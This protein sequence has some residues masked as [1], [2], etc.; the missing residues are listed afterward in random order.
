[1]KTLTFLFLGVLLC[2]PSPSFA[3]DRRTA[4]RPKSRP[5]AGQASAIGATAPDARRADQDDGVTALSRLMAKDPARRGNDA[6]L[7]MSDFIWSR[8]GDA[9]SFIAREIMDRDAALKPGERIRD[10][11]LGV[12]R[13]WVGEN[14]A[15][16]ARIYF[17][18]GPGPAVPGWLEAEPSVKKL[19][20]D[21]SRRC[22][23]VFLK[24]IDR[25]TGPAEARA[26]GDKAGKGPKDDPMGRMK[27]AFTVGWV[28]AFLADAAKQA[29][30]AIFHMNKPKEPV[31]ADIKKDEDLPAPP[32]GTLAG[33][34]SKDP[35]AGEA[36][37]GFGMRYLY[38]EWGQEN[39]F[40]LKGNC[41][42]GPGGTCGRTLSITRYEDKDEQGRTVAGV[43][44]CDISQESDVFCR[45]FGL[46]HR[47]K[48]PFVLD[49]RDPGSM[50][51][52]LS[53]VPRGDDME[54][55]LAR[56]NGTKIQNA[57]G[58]HSIT[59]NRLSELK[60]GQIR[61]EGRTVLMGG[62][63]YYVGAQ[64]GDYLFILKEKLDGVSGPAGSR[65]LV[66]DFLVHAVE[67]VGRQNQVKDGQYIGTFR[68]RVDGVDKEVHYC[69]SYKPELNWFKPEASDS[70]RKPEPRP[71]PKNPKAAAQGA[72]GA[73][74]RGGTAGA[75]RTQA[76]PGVAQDGWPVIPGYSSDEG[77][78]KALNDKIAVENGSKVAR[79]Y[80]KSDEPD[81][82][83]RWAIAWKGGASQEI[84]WLQGGVEV[85]ADGRVIAL[86]LEDRVQWLDMRSPWERKAPD[87]GQYVMNHEPHLDGYY[88][89]ETGT[90]P[91]KFRD[92]RSES[93][94]GYAL[95]RTEFQ[96]E[97]IKTIG[98]RARRV[99]GLI[100]K[101]GIAKDAF[102]P[103]NPPRAIAVSRKTD[104]RGRPPVEFHG[105]GGEKKEVGMYVEGKTIHLFPALRA[106]PKEEVETS[107]QDGGRQ[108]YDPMQPLP[109]DGDRLGDAI[110]PSGANVKFTRVRQVQ[111]NPAEA[112][113]Y[114]GEV[115]GVRRWYLKFVYKGIKDN[116]N[117][118]FWS[119]EALVFALPKSDAASLPPADWSKVR[120]AGMDMKGAANPPGLP[121]SVG[122]YL[123]SEA[124]RS[125]EKAP[126]KGVWVVHSEAT[127]VAGSKCL[128]PVLWWGMSQEE[129][130]KACK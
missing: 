82:K 127:G 113:L 120:M 62:R 109:A 61:G 17:V 11:V 128:G 51:Y 59:F 40:L 126:E 108:K 37:G 14:P 80:L 129:A 45:K 116:P 1:M 77:E 103:G 56:P 119:Q 92:V 106:H 3:T 67:R 52:K 48:D 81:P 79:L 36:A 89:P 23:P 57:D 53:L 25:W 43:L 47:S 50:K 111:A 42:Q 97:E 4:K 130:G 102:G 90:S 38:G 107:R 73:Y 98:D 60:A 69:L 70:C 15:D 99:L 44:I 20:V 7:R 64:P 49:D 66:P 76:R 8:D 125:G 32:G 6:A 12:V 2:P 19:V 117:Q 121:R 35:L 41:G 5:A 88:T 74:S 123:K 13:K 71:D 72:G 22:M 26:D 91:A 115:D 28:E 124:V 16:A 114:E 18:L 34:P 78:A 31:R 96:P 33:G 68:E 9:R 112:L 29:H 39:V 84:Y 122:R 86:E 54:I 55:V 87:N 118:R 105:R 24:N 83:R 58:K 21:G 93:M 101:G 110:Y 94:L 27:G 63:A 46:D 75:R 100:E 95:S 85:I 10:R 104:S 30:E 65:D